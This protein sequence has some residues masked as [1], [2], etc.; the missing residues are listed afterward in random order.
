MRSFYE[1][2][3]TEYEQACSL[4]VFPPLIPN[5]SFQ[6]S[7]QGFEVNTRD[8]IRGLGCLLRW[9]GCCAIFAYYQSARRLWDRVLAAQCCGVDVRHPGGCQGSLWE[10]PARF[11]AANVAFA[12]LAERMIE[13]S[14]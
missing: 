7:V 12:F 14:I 13:E 2:P 10:E 1:L 3:H 4:F 9:S 5:C 8:G 6:A 11:K